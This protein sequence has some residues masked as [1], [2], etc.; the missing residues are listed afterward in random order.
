MVIDLVRL[1][2]VISL[3]VTK[4]TS[5]A[6]IAVLVTGVVQEGKETVSE[7]LEGTKPVTQKGS[8]VGLVDIVG[9]GSGVGQVVFC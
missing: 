9:D 2:T 7:V 1:R 6:P 5:K 4:V 8:G 3:F